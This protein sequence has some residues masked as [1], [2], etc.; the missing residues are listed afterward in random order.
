MATQIDL[1][2]KYGFPVRGFSGQ[3]LLVD[4]NMQRKIVEALEPLP[5]EPVLEIG[6]GLGALTGQLLRHGCRVWAIEKDSR[7][8]EVLRGEYGSEYPD[9]LT[10]LEADALK[11]PLDKWHR[12]EGKRLWKLAS[13]LPYYITAPLLM[14]ILHYRHIFSRA[15]LMMQREVARRLTAVPG[16]RDYSR[17]TLAVRYAAEARLL[18]DIPPAC[19]TP[20]PSVVSTVVE[21]TFHPPVK[22]LEKDEEAFL[23]YLIRRAFGERRKTVLGILQRDQAL[24]F[25]REALEEVFREHD[26][27]LRA[28][29]EDLLL[30][31]FMNLASELMRRADLTQ[32]LK[33]TE[34]F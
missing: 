15:V 10:V 28:R 1:L 3:H 4:P 19:F 17:L 5:E 20:K 22:R 7:F 13:N 25:S 27:K 16:S 29:A 26:L 33:F 31:D 9:Q 34:P 14:H 24:G 11:V 21:L 23:F 12:Q 32:K 2:K 6:P 18:F 30:K 8:A